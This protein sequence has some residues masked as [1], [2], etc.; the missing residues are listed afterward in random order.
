MTKPLLSFYGDDFTGS[1]DALEALSKA[2]LKTVLFLGLPR[3]E[4]L[5]HFD[6]VDAL[7]IAGMSRAMSPSDMKSAL[8]PAFERLRSFGAPVVH[9]KV[10]STFDSSP[11]VG[12]IGCAIDLGQEM[13]Q[14]LFV[15]L[16][17]GAPV[18]GRYCVFGN[19]FARSGL[20]S[21]PY[22]LDRHPTMRHHP[23]TPMDE[24]DI[25]LHLAKQTDK[26]I[27]LVDVLNLASPEADMTRDFGALLEDRPDIVLF[28]TLEDAH[29]PRI[30][31]L[32]WHHAS[33]E[34]PLFTVGSSGVEYAL[35][36]YWREAGTL[37]GA[38]RDRKSVV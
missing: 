18:L 30:G 15:P 35:S 37:P 32:I 36:A 26:R 17:V 6:G 33:P 19:L 27:A 14:S 2:G 16:V 8:P 3:D 22:R 34:R 20:E 11:E 4:T 12:S 28:D 1:T 9:Y 5:K 25:R 23:V 13:F 38:P 7:G 24:A 31:K 10:C 21:E 29:L